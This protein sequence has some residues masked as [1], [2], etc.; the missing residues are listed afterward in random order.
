MPV[1]AMPVKFLTEAEQNYLQQQLKRVKLFLVFC[2]INII[3]AAGLLIAM[4][5]DWLH[6]DSARLVLAIILLLGARSYLRLYK[7]TRLLEKFSAQQAS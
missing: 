6:Y 7:S 4:A 1:Y 2:I 3:V 5:T